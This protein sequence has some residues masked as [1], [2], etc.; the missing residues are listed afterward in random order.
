VSAE[1]AAVR[2]GRNLS[3]FIRCLSMSRLNASLEIQMANT[4]K[5]MAA[6]MMMLGAVGPLAAEQ[7]YIC[8]E[9]ASG[10]V[11]FV[12]ESRS[13]GAT[14]FR[15]SNRYILTEPKPDSDYRQLAYIVTQIGS[16][17]PEYSCPN[18]ASEGGYI[19]CSGFGGSFRFN[20]KTLRY[21]ATY[22]LG[23]VYGEVPEDQTG[24]TPFVSVGLCAPF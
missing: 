12:P 4:I 21:L 22:E 10:G 15:A 16:S 24:N 2:S 23:F 20:S 1:A 14:T 9:V 19:F 7:R 5:M 6:V 18:R 8:D 3:Y 13:W 11:K 17:H